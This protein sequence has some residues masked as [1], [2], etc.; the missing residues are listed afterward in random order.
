MT[1]PCPGLALIICAPSG[2]GKSTLIKSFLKEFPHFSFSISYTTRK[3]RAG[4]QHGREYFFVSPEKFKK[5]IKEDFFAE[6]AEVHSNF[7]G[8]PLQNTL[9]ILDSGQDILFDI[10]VQGAR[11]LKQSLQ[12]GAYVF[13][14][15]PSKE[16]LE[17]RLSGRGSEDKDRIRQRVAAAK[18]EIKL[19]K[20]FDYCLLNQEL[21]E[22]YNR[23]RAIYLAEKC[24]IKFNQNLLDTVLR[25]WQEG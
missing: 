16:V 7:Y 18:K 24:R 2:A 11:Q 15:P 25:T 6:W 1:R 4:E 21:Q 10:D 19:A 9:D 14:L 3:P 5:L 22:A 13:I 23:L 20:E 12:F 8:T 17:Q